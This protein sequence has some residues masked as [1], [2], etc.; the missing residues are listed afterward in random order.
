M[1]YLDYV[2]REKVQPNTQSTMYTP[3]YHGNMELFIYMDIQ[4][5]DMTN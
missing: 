4:Y 3:T 2:I 1:L 5:E